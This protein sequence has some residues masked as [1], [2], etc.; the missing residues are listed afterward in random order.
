MK[1][2]SLDSDQWL[3][4]HKRTFKITFKRSLVTVISWLET[5]WQRAGRTESFKRVSGY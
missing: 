2:V 3:I 5:P 1:N 4:H